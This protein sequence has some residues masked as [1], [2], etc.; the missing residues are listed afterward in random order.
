MKKLLQI[1]LIIGIVVALALGMLVSL[2][3]GATAGGTTCAR[4]GWN[5]RVMCGQ[6]AL[7][8]SPP[9]FHPNVGWNT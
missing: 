3:A 8:S 4:V 6:T 1:S 2:D 5:D 9:I 7:L